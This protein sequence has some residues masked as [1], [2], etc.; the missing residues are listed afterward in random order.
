MTERELMKL[1]VSPTE[2]EPGHALDDE[3]ADCRECRHS[4][5]YPDNEHALGCIH[6]AVAMLGHAGQI[7]GVLA[8]AVYKLDCHGEWKEKIE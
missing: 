5:R 7:I 1:P 8:S 4:R 2:V 6:P 3:Q